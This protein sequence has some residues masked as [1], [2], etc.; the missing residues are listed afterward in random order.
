MLM[1]HFAIVAAGLAVL[2]AP[3][4][5]AQMPAPKVVADPKAAPGGV[6]KLDPRHAS[7]IV[8]LAHMGLSHYSMRFDTIAGEYAFD[9]A[10]PAASKVSVTIDPKSVDTNDPKFNAEIAGFLGADQF[11]TITFTSTRIIPGPGDKGEVEGV[12][13][14]HGVQKPVTLHVTYR[15]FVEMMKQQR[16]GFSGE[17]TFKRSEFGVSNLVPVV[18]DEV[19]VLI[20]VEFVKQ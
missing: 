18:G 10:S 11:P 1:K 6:Y 2:G 4:A 5:M 14:F 3:V 13:N 8:K 7:A 12:L 17:T 20:E 9:P 15:G 19:T 16:M